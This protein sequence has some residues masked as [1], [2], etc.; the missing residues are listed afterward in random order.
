MKSLLSLLLSLILT[1]PAH[2]EEID[3]PNTVEAYWQWS[4]NAAQSTNLGDDSESV[5]LCLEKIYGASQDLG[6]CQ[7]AIS[8]LTTLPLNLHRREILIS[9]LRKI[10]T[11]QLNHQQSE[12]MK[13][14]LLTHPELADESLP[15][16]LPAKKNQVLVPAVEVKAWLKVLSQKTNLSKAWISLNGQSLTLVNHF[17]FPIGVYQWAL[18]TSDLEP[19]V[20]VGTWADFS[21]ELKNLKPQAEV[22]QWLPKKQTWKPADH[23]IDLPTTTMTSTTKASAHSWILPV[24]LVVA[25]GL[26][27]ALKDKQVTVTMP[28]QH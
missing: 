16:S 1:V 4:Q 26:V 10:P 17:S 19:L 2:G 13:G 6:I 8:D 9:L 25:A 28:G 14:L 20:I 27:F 11:T 12:L 3:N 22:A 18:V 23:L 21:A 5:D 15:T 24:V 7:K